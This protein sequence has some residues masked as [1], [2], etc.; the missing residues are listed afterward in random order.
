[1]EVQLELDSTES[2]TGVFVYLH[3]TINGMYNAK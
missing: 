3:D 2:Y 1:M